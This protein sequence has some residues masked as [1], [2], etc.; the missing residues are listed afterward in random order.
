VL[1]R[2]MALELRTNR[3]RH[4]VAVELVGR[5]AALAGLPRALRERRAIQA[6]RTASLEHVA[7]L[8]R[9]PASM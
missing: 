3:P 7:A 8:L 1:A 9:A 6:T 4:L 5:A 2:R